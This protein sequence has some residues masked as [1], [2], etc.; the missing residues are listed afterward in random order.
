MDEMPIWQ[1]G[2]IIDARWQETMGFTVD[3]LSET[4]Q[5]RQAGLVVRKT[6][7]ADQ[8]ANPLYSGDNSHEA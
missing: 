3:W 8:I 1:P 2:G 6:R 7:S 5:N 4:L